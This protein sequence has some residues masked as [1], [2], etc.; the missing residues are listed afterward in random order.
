MCTF[1]HDH[2]TPFCTRLPFE[3]A[4]DN[5]ER[6][7]EISIRSSKTESSSKDKFLQPVDALPLLCAL[8]LC[9]PL[10]TRTGPDGNGAFLVPRSLSVRPSEDPSSALDEGRRVLELTLEADGGSEGREEV[11]EERRRRRSGKE[12][13][14]VGVEDQGD[15][16]HDLE[17]RQRAV[18]MSVDARADEFED[19]ERR[20]SAREG[21]PFPT[22][23]Q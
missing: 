14:E 13:R 20:T 18:Y 16:R 17:R 23:T 10:G 22:S 1:T 15:E 11:S 3:F 19:K 12:G 7:K 9:P 8:R 5:C 21:R 4:D 6:G 2:D